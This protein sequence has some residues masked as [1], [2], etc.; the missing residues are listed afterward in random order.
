[1]TARR[2]LPWIALV[3][4]AATLLAMVAPVAAQGGDGVVEARAVVTG[5]NPEVP[6]AN[7]PASLFTYVDGQRQP[8]PLA[9]MTDGQGRVRF[10]GLNTA[11]NYTYTVIVR[12][13]EAFYRAEGVT[14]APGTRLVSPIITLPAPAIAAGGIRIEQHH[15]VIDVDPDAKTIGIAVFLQI[16]NSTE[17]PFTGTPDAGA[18]NKSVTLRIPLPPDADDIGVEGRTPNVDVFFSGGALLDAAPV[19]P[20]GGGLIFSYRVP[21]Q[22]STYAFNI[23]TPMTTTALNVLVAPGVGLRAQRLVSQGPVQDL[24]LKYTRYLARDLPPGT[25]IAVELTDLPA[26][27]VP[28]DVLQWLPLALSVAGLL[29]LLVYSLR[30]RR[31]A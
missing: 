13:Q 10:E 24:N 17:A 3:A 26:A 20:G 16:A 31:V 23:T 21:F 15:I 19:P 1:M 12:Y 8:T 30:A 18:N 27:F 28:L 2:M 25:T 11:S 29:A 14:F 22:R 9:G 5:T 6:G 4:C 7:L